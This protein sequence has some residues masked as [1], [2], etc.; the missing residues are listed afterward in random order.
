ME[1]TGYDIVKREGKGAIWLETATDLNSARSRIKQIL[2]FW[3]GRYEVVEQ[4]SQRIVA[5][6]ASS[7][8]M[9]VALKGTWEYANKLACAS[10]EWLLA[11]APSIAGLAAYARAQAYAR[12]CY[13]WSSQWLH[14]PMARAPIPPGR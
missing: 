9:R 14:G 4:G 2:S 8:R 3:P 12:N 6:T 5:A 13:R 7:V 10:Y 11:P 1:V